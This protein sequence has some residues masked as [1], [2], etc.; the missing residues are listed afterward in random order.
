MK[1]HTQQTALTSKVKKMN[2]RLHKFRE[3]VNAD[4]DILAHHV[5][6]A[7]MI[8]KFRDKDS[9]LERQA[10]VPRGITVV[11][12]QEEACALFNYPR[13]RLE[14]VGLSYPVDGIAAYDQDGDVS[15]QLYI[16]EMLASYL[17]PPTLRLSCQSNILYSYVPTCVFILVGPSGFCLFL[18]C[19]LSYWKLKIMKISTTLKRSGH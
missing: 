13:E 3:P 17:A 7:L 12:L 18:H 14:E 15:A 2:S 19:R 16:F 1:E 9:A 11:E 4:K 8:V 10:N 5:G 6:E